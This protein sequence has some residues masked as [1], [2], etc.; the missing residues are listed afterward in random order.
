M[1]DVGGT[2]P[3]GLV[4]FLGRRA[5]ITEETGLREPVSNMEFEC[6]IKATGN[7]TRKTWKC[8]MAP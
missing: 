2:S 8:N 5:W 6:F 1:S 3:L 7:Q 4:S